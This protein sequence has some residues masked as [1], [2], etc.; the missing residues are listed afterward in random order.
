MCTP[1]NTVKWW[2]EELPEVAIQRAHSSY[3]A[4]LVDEYQ[5]FLDD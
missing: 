2:N 1:K 4:V 5:D 3:D